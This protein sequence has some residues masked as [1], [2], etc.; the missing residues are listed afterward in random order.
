MKCTWSC[1]VRSII[2]NGQ[3]VHF[4]ISK[5][6]HDLQWSCRCWENYQQTYF[7]G[8]VWVKVSDGFDAKH[9]SKIHTWGMGVNRHSRAI[10]P[11]V[12]NP[13]WILDF[14]GGGVW[15]SGGLWLNS[16]ESVHLPRLSILARG[17]SSSPKLWRI[18]I[19]IRECKMNNILKNYKLS[20]FLG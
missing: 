13:L 8:G 9:Q 17:S 3:S 12:N 10:T 1:S 18:C 11:V 5:F 19:K 20:F 2:E 16:H 14:S 7:Y 6:L 15:L 4:H